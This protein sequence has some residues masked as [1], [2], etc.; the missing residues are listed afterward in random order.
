MS[1]ELKPCPFC[2]SN[3]VLTGG[4]EYGIAVFCKNC[5]SDG[6]VE[7]SDAEAITAWNTRTPSEGYNEGDGGK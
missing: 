1:E 2:G 6:P 4:K 3:I 7:D 5:F